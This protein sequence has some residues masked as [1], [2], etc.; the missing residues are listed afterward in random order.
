[1][2]KKIPQIQ[3]YMT[4][5]PVTIGS[6]ESLQSAKSIMSEL[7][8]RH[9]PVVNEGSILGVISARDIDFIQ[10]IRGT[11]LATQKVKDAMTVEPYIVS[12]ETELAE[13]CDVMASQKI[14]SVLVQDNKK[15]VGIFTWVDALNAMAELMQTR[16]K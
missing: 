1:M 15:L 5:T 4:T 16:L 10:G 13:V 14:G 8:I 6:Q 7:N 2:T 3:R 9:L 12:A 11:D